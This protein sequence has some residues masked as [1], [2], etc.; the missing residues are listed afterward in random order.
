ML[1]SITEDESFV[2]VVEN[3]VLFDLHLERAE[4]GRLKG[5]ICKGVVTKVEPAL[6][7]A[8]VDFGSTRNGFLAL[9]DLNPRLYRKPVPKGQRARIQDVLAKGQELMVQILKEPIGNKGAALTTNISLPGRYLVMMPNS[10]SGGISRKIENEEQRKRLKDILKKLSVPEG[11]GIIIRTAGIERTKIELERDLASLTRLWSNIKTSFKTSPK[12]V[13]FMEQDVVIRA[14]RDYFDTNSAEVVIDDEEAYKRVQE[15]V[16]A[17]MPRQIKKFRLY[18]SEIPLFVAEGVERQIDA[19]YSSKV[20]LASGGALVIEPTEALVT[21]DVNSGKSL[22]ERNVEDTALKTNLEA[23]RE[24]ARQL[25]LRDLG[26]LVVV[27]FIDMREEKH[28]REVER[29]LRTALKSDKART[30]VG[31]ISQFGLLEMS[32]QRIRPALMMATQIPCPTCQG[33]GVVVSAESGA[34]RAL[35]RLRTEL[36]GAGS[37]MGAIRVDLPRDD[38]V[39]LLNQHR[40]ALAQMEMRTGVRIEI[41]PSDLPLGS[42]GQYTLIAQNVKPVSELE[43]DLAS[44]NSNSNGNGNG[45]GNRQSSSAGGSRGASGS[46]NGNG[47]GNGNGGGSVSGSGKTGTK[48]GAGTGAG[49]SSSGAAHDSESR[50]NPGASGENKAGVKLGTPAR[51]HASGDTHGPKPH[52]NQANQHTPAVPPATPSA[53]SITSHANENREKTHAHTEGHVPAQSSAGAAPATGT[54]RVK[55]D[56]HGHGHGQ[57]HGDKAA[58]PASAAVGRAGLEVNEAGDSENGPHAEEGAETAKSEGNTLSKSARRRRRRKKKNYNSLTENGGDVHSTASSS[59]S[60]ISDDGTSTIMKVETRENTEVAVEKTL[61]KPEMAET[62]THKPAGGREVKVTKEA[63][64]AEADGAATGVKSESVPVVSSTTPGENAEESSLASA[65][66]STQAKSSGRVTSRGRTPRTSNR[67][68][69]ASSTTPRRQTQSKSPSDSSS[70]SSSIKT[71]N[72]TTTTTQGKEALEGD[73]GIKG[74][75]GGGGDV[76]LTG[77][78]SPSST[79]VKRQS[80][81]AVVSKT[82]PPTRTGQP[83][84]TS[85]TPSTTTPS[86]D[87][88]KPTDGKVH[89]QAGAVSPSGNGQISDFDRGELEHYLSILDDAIFRNRNSGDMN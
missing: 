11:H 5:N 54:D 1:I 71:A 88:I 68:S 45:N 76:G 35:R 7:A 75:D 22:G 3:G 16:R 40:G 17:T 4:I 31:K 84:G 83:A 48:G 64:Q 34:R 73:K 47:N 65:S 67:T 38:A 86:H 12:G 50:A 55:D 23:A 80:K 82:T 60:I 42:P 8:F 53:T 33:K 29:E 25:R 69:R 15:Y 74:V 87:G 2:A 28:I 13:V 72:S 26:G 79:P 63:K 14:V 66:G 6:Q 36:I 59:D 10:D 81:P 46:A 78:G 77:D 39:S 32:R 52:P 37:E 58:R 44:I 18:K 19:V 62:K 27:D 61:A 41:I 85:E 21:V 57:R 49:S 30:Q 56:G 70:S 9:D 43:N 20:S 89:N 24:V 51:N